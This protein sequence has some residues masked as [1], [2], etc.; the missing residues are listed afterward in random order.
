VAVEPHPVG[1]RL[2]EKVVQAIAKGGDP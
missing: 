2:G 1:Q